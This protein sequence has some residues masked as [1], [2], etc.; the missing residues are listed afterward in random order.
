MEETVHYAMAQ[1]PKA[2][3]VLLVS[4]GVSGTAREILKY[5]V[6]RWTTWS[7]TR[8]VLAVAR[9]LLR[10]SLADPRIRVLT[11]D[12]RLYVKQTAER[13]DVVILDVP[14]P[15]TSQMNR[16]YTREFFAEVRRVLVPGGVLALSIGHYDEGY[17]DPEMSRVLAI[18]L[19]DA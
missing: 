5:G 9:R 6:G 3:R 19:P 18:G 1:R 14:E 17:L 7:S 15:S 8:L 10:E 11:T 4:G 13:Y 16:F 12:G 2:R